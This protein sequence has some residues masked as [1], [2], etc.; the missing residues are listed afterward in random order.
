MRAPEPIAVV[1]LSCPSP[2]AAGADV[3]WRLLCAGTGSG[4]PG[5]R[6]DDS[7]DF[8]PAF[9]GIAPHVADAMDPRQRLALELA[10]GALESACIEPAALRST[11]TGLF[12]GDMSDPQVH[13]LSYV[14][15]LR[16]PGLGVGAGLSAAPDAVH[17]ACEGLRRGGCEIALAGGAHL[18]A[19]SG[20]S[21]GLV[22]LKTLTR[23]QRDGDRIHALIRGG[24]SYTTRVDGPSTEGRTAFL[25]TGQGSQRVGMGRELYAAFPAFARAF[26]EVC[27]AVGGDLKAVVFGEDE[28]LLART[29]FTQPAIFAVEVA[30]FR[31]LESWGA[32]PDA[33]SGHSI[34]EIAAAHVAGVLSLADAARLV[35]ARGRL[36]QALPEGGVM[37]A[38]MASEDQVRPLLSGFEDR[39]GIAAVNGPKAVVLSGLAEVVDEIVA[40]LKGQGIKSRALKVS[41]AFHSPLMAPMLDEFGAVAHELTYHSAHIPIVSTVT[42]RLTDVATADYWVRHVPATVRFHDAIRALER[43]GVTT[44]VELGP[45]AVCTAMGKSCVEGEDI[46]FVPTL[47]RK[48][49]EA[50]TLFGALGDVVERGGSIEWESFAGDSA[51]RA[52]LRDVL[53]D[54]ASGA[55]TLTGSLAPST[56]LSFAHVTPLELALH[57]GKVTGAERVD[58]L[59]LEAPLPAP[60]RGTVQLC[61]SVTEADSELRRTV[62]LHSRAEQDGPWTRHA[63]GV[64]SQAGTRDASVPAPAAV[65]AKAAPVAEAAPA[66]ALADA[67]ED[68][69]DSVALGRGALFAEEWAGLDT[70]TGPDGHDRFAVVGRG[71]AQMAS[72]AVLGLDY[73]EFPDLTALAAS[74]RVPGTVVVP[75]LER[76]GAEPGAARSVVGRVLSLVQE[77]LADE[78]FAASR[79]VLL[80]RG[81]AGDDPAGAALWGLVRAAATEHP[82][83]FALVD[84]DDDPTSRALLPAVFAT[85]EPETTVRA[86]A[87]FARRLSPLDAAAEGGA[88]F[89][90]GAVLVTGGTGTF[91]A[92]VARHLVRAHG[93]KELV[94]TQRQGAAGAEADGL[95]RELTGLGARMVRVDVCDIADRRQAR[96]LL[97]SVP[98]LSAVVHTAA[99][100][101]DVR[102]TALTADRLDAVFGAT[103]QAAWNL[104]ELTRD[105]GQDPAAFV[106]FSSAAGVF[107]S[108]GQ[109]DSASAGC[110]VDALVRRRVAEGLPGLSLV[111][112]PWDDVPGTVEEG[113]ALFDAARATAA[114][115][116]VPAPVD[117]GAMRG[118]SG[119]LPPLLRKAGH[120]PPRGAGGQGGAVVS[121]PG[122][123]A[124]RERLLA[125]PEGERADVVLDMVRTQVAKALRWGDPRA[126]PADRTF[127]ALGFDSLSTFELRNALGALTGLRLSATVLFDY[128]DP[129]VLSAYL[130]SRLLPEAEPA[131]LVLDQIDVLAAMVA[132]IGP[133]DAL[134]AT[135]EV[136]LRTVLSGLSSATIPAQRHTVADEIETATADELLELIDAEFDARKA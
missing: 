113:L 91:G 22:V 26:D 51:E 8:D 89:G 68:Q 132:A 111:W 109:A 93:V 107:G 50:E 18:D 95:V 38:V 101:D 76:S 88:G 104:H 121:A 28:A 47:R 5:G 98:R 6:G 131:A 20:G 34:G 39:A 136:R 1:G 19:G 46:R 99:F 115:A 60:G 32:L 94:L 96:A 14:L 23:A 73:D 43:D 66:L 49:P 21:G 31:L 27:E 55:V 13:R 65:R 52:A 133:D 116:V 37:V 128:P 42:G 54:P 85:D 24:A 9:F 62:H 25:F 29:E 110:Y 103:A 130:L 105:L 108:A 92:L 36:M 70:V 41:H 114:C 78:R 117:L 2:Q 82:G 129:A 44:F 16:G 33:L 119:E 102:V 122:G 77:W 125:L 10:R 30:L 59:T 3:F 79:L 64:L 112:G 53:T 12:V 69:V 4:E 56:D 61:L 83:R 87:L 90:R 124:L 97:E 63:T 75:F 17:Q 126:V 106:V 74:G 134:R 48:R 15:G 40:A 86:G 135:A 7:P 123:D 80:T 45:D 127:E 118:A 58:E 11:R 120:A 100:L 67:E 72:A 71:V 35:G 81:A 84:T 57:A